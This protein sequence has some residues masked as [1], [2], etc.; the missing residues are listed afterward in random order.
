MRIA[1]AFIYVKKSDLFLI[2]FVLIKTLQ[3]VRKKI[4]KNKFIN[5]I[6]L[7]YI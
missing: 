5:A 1:C 2:E 4:K 7:L 3:L 6:K